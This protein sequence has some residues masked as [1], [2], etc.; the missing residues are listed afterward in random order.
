MSQVFLPPYVVNEVN[1][2][3]PQSQTVDWGTNVLRIPEIHSLGITGQGVVVAVVDTGIDENH[4]DLVNSIQQI[5]NVTGEGMKASN[6]HGIGC[7]GIIAAQNNN[8]GILGTAP[9]AKII[10]I[11][12]MRESGGGSISEIIA[13]IDAAIKA[14][15]QVINL[16]LGTTSDVPSLKAAI[17]RAVSAGIYVVCSAGNAGQDNSVVYPAR[18]DVT[19]AIGATNQSGNVS[20]F[21]SRGWEVDIAA[22]G[23]RILT[24]WRNRS[25]ARVSGTSFS[26][27]YVSGLFALFL[28]AELYITHERLQATAIDIEEPGQDTKSGHGLINPLQFIKTYQ[29]SVTQAPTPAPVAVDPLA[30][31]REAYQLLGEYLGQ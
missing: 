21:S 14:G 8:E 22:P 13:G 24:T 28:S 12:A 5:I 17:D 20:A 10:G 27:P 15:A 16:S 25:Y 31:V 30:K 19:Y 9:G 7:A 18:Y 23:E 2:V 1:P 26:A 4:P 11:K 3:L 29:G 6:G